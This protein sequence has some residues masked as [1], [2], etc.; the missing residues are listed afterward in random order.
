MEALVVEN[1]TEIRIGKT[2]YIV[3]SEYSPNAT[4]NVAQKLKKLIL[5]HVFGNRKVIR[6]LSERPKSQLE[7]CPY[8][9]E[10]EYGKT[11]TGRSF[12]LEE[13]AS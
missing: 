4:E 6:K 3:T 11:K 8:P 9:S 10:Y 5:Q 1:T 2:L 12:N 7:A 13:P